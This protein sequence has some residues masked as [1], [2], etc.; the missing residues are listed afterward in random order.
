MKQIRR[1]S[2]RIARLI[3]VG[4]AV[5]LVYAI[6]CGKGVPPA[7]GQYS[8][9]ILLGTTSGIPDV[10]L[11]SELDGGLARG[12]YFQRK[13][14]VG[15]VL[16][17]VYDRER[18]YYYLTGALAQ[19]V[20]QFDPATRE[21]TVLYRAPGNTSIKCLEISSECSCLYFLEQEGLIEFDLAGRATTVLLRQG[22]D[23]LERFVMAR[24]TGALYVDRESGV[25]R[26][27]SGSEKPKLV[28][29]NVKLVA[30]SPE[31]R[32]IVCIPSREE[33]TP[34]GAP[35][36]LCLHVYGPD[37]EPLDREF[38]LTGVDDP[39]AAF[40]NER[41]LAYERSYWH[42]S[43]LPSSYG[44]FARNIETGEERR[45]TRTYMSKIWIGKLSQQDLVRLKEREER[46][47]ALVQSQT[48]DSLAP[49]NQET[50]E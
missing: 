50:D 7:P 43:G 5:L 44:V 36:P 39:G 14:L 24:K 18:G 34:G 46:G 37:G 8:D 47:L 48:N 26:L 23:R 25:Y 2:P 17:G 45:L 38:F 33:R 19:S 22:E 20:V 49:Q 42:W 30:V 40:V 41:E 29:Q 11:R 27:E 12:V 15:H 28:L 3:L 32:Y 4:T 35:R 6:G 13:G 31:G 10:L 16:R 9:R 1:R 21:E